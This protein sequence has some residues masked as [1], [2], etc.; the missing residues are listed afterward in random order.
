LWQQITGNVVSHQQQGNSIF[1]EGLADRTDDGI[2]V[3][4]K[5]VKYLKSLGY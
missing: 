1:N 3:T 2:R 4:D 5:G